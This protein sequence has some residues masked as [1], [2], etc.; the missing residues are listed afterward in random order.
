[1]EIDFLFKAQR[2]LLFPFQLM[3]LILTLLQYKGLLLDVMGIL[4]LFGFDQLLNHML[5]FDQLERI[6][7]LKGNSLLQVLS[8]FLQLFLV[9]LEELIFHLLTLLLIILNLIIPVFLECLHFVIELFVELLSFLLLIPFEIDFLFLFKDLSK[10][11]KF[12][13]RVFGVLLAHLD[14][15]CLEPTLA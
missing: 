15:F 12:Q 11:L 13:M 7:R 5:E 8:I 6:L 2:N 14:T 10:L 3:L 1:M 9:M 4:I